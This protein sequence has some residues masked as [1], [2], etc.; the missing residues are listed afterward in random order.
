LDASTDGGIKPSSRR[1]SPAAIRQYSTSSSTSANASVRSGLPW[2][3]V[4]AR[5]RSSRRS[6]MIAATRSIAAAR[7]KAEREAHAPA[8][9]LAAAI[10]RPASSRVACGTDPIVSPVAGLVA[11]IRPPDSLSTH[12]PPTYIE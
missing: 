7:S 2:S 8:A 10:A 9:A 5:A 6:S 12:E 1:A 11:S 4:S 3:S